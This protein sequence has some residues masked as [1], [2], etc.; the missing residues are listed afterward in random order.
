WRAAAAGYEPWFEPRAIVAHRHAGTLAGFIRQRMARG[1]EFGRLRAAYEHWSK[2]RLIVTIFA[3]PLL[4]IWV[5][6]R[7]ARDAANGGWFGRYLW[8]LPVQVAGHG[9]WSAGE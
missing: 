6:L 3:T 5:L 7:A 2:P 1:A 9:S 8:T 4:V